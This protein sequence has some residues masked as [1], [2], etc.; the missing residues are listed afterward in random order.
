MNHNTYIVTC[1]KCNKAN[2]INNMDRA[3]LIFIIKLKLLIEFFSLEGLTMSLP[4]NSAQKIRA[5]NRLYF[6]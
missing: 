4:S 3:F 5:M 1:F 6:S 2:N